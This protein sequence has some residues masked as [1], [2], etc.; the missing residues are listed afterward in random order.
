[1]ATKVYI[2]DG[3]KT[4]N[5]LSVKGINPFE[6]DRPGAW[7]DNKDID[8]LSSRLVPSMF[9]GVSA[10]M[11]AMAD[12]PFTI[13][14]VN[15][16]KELDNSDNY[17]NALGFMPRP[18]RFLSMT[19]GA[20]CLTGQAYWYKG[21]GTKTGA[22][23]ELKYWRP[24]S[25]TLNTTAAQKNEI[26]FERKGTSQKFTPDEVL[27]FWGHDPL[28]ELGA[29]AAYPFLSALVAAQANGAITKWTADYMKRGAIKAMM[30]MVDGMPPATEV[31]RMESWFNRFMAG[32]KNMAWKV[33]NSQGVK[34]TI[35]GDGLEA[36]RD[37]SINSDLRYEV[38]Q[39]LGTRHLL[40]DE[41]FAT[42]NAR[43]R[44]FYQIT[45]VPNARIIQNE[46][47][48]Q[49]LHA[50]GFHLEFEPERL[51]SFQED[52]GIQVTA[53]GQLLEVFMRG[54]PF[55]TAFQLAA[56]KLDYH[57]TDEQKAMI[58]GALVKKEKPVE[59][60]APEPIAP[61]PI[62]EP[63]ALTEAAKT[64]TELD[65]LERRL[66]KSNWRDVKFHCVRI[67]TD[68][69]KALVAKTM[70]FDEARA[71]AK[72]APDQDNDALKALAASLDRVVEAAS[73]ET[74]APSYNFSMPPIT[75]TTNMP[76]QGS[77][78]VNVPDQFTVKK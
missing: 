6:D 44:Q 71:A 8:A 18:Y 76:A 75:L 54:L 42:A 29:P 63:D 21:K 24:D 12:M 14:S 64:I 45:I 56:E 27:Y 9:A 4:E 31:E 11:Q 13:Y 38:H 69:Y 3:T 35:I 43:E 16:D 5:I 33:F 49:A 20:L 46:L 37:L 17:L 70:T 1:M 50:M 57:F 10:R 77:I 48:E 15:G 26:V 51:E 61:E 30:L 39:A 52:E 32:T 73:K 40:E 60:I 55:D 58:A 19:E 28:V 2:T 62:A 47:N 68:T 59:I 53:F 65:A 25:V 36:L 72:V 41:N 7:T 67:D 34:P 66:V 74:V 78:T 23:K 22:I